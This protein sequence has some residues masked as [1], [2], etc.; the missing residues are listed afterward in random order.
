[1]IFSTKI[2][3]LISQDKKE[4]ITS[5]EE[6]AALAE[7]GADQ[8]IFSESENKIIQTYLIFKN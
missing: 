5:R 3:K 1:M 6:I 8:G 4:N 2:T 7:I